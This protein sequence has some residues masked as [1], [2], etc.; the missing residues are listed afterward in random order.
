MQ[1]Q[2][3][4]ELKGSY[5]EWN[6]LDMLSKLLDIVMSPIKQQMMTRQCGQAHD[7]GEIKQHKRLSTYCCKLM[8]RIVAELTDTAVNVRVST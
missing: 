3:K 4:P 7:H 5:T 2:E 1:S 8:A 6:L